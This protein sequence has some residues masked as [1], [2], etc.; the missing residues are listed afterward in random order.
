MSRLG[1]RMVHARFLPSAILVA[2]TILG[3]AGRTR[4][5]EVET[6]IQ[7]WGREL[8]PPRVG[9]QSEPPVAGQKASEA[10][11]ARKELKGYTLPP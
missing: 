6:V 1:A 10:V 7:S 5:A 9:E 2:M 3:S 11:G 4:G 8:N